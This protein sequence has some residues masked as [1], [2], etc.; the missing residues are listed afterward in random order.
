MSNRFKSTKVSMDYIDFLA[1]GVFTI[2]AII[3]RV[4]GFDFR[5]T[6]YNVFLNNWVNQIREEGG[7]SALGHRIGDYT[8]LYMYFLAFLSYFEAEPLYGI[9]VFSSA[10]DFFA[11]VIIFKLIFERTGSKFKAI[12]AYGVTLFIPTIFLNS[13]VWAQCDSLYSVLTFASIYVLVSEKDIKVW[14]LDK[15]C[16]AMILY[17]IAFSL[18]LQSIFALPVFCLFFLKNKLKMRYILLVPLVYFITVLPSVFLGREL[19]ECLSIYINQM[20]EYGGFTLNYPNFYTFT[21]GFE[22]LK[23]EMIIFTF[24]LLFMV[25]YVILKSKVKIDYDLIIKYLVFSVL[26]C[27]YFLPSMHER[28]AFIVELAVLYYVFI[29]P[30]A[31][32]LFIIVQ[33]SGIITYFK[34]LTGLPLG[35]AEINI[36]YIILSIGRLGCVIYTAKDLICSY[37]KAE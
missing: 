27:T 18:K 14:K 7:F 28:Y 19:G 33:L 34:Y 11:S 22:D 21:N 4:K 23:A 13:A 17:G 32:L 25:L 3:I 20:G 5:S 16:I 2:L 30:K 8:P 37:G 26:T 24:I 36:L 12:V 1:I 6:D 29:N 31:I 9:K 15:Q 35:D 10:F